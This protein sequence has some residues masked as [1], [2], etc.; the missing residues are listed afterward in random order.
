MKKLIY[1]TIASFLLINIP[2]CKKG[3][4]DQLPQDRT[5]IEQVFAH[6]NTV[7]NFLANVYSYVR[8]EAS[9]RYIGGSTSG[10]PWTGASD[11]AE[12]DWSFVFSNYIN[13]GAWGPT[14]GVVNDF[15]S[16]YYTAIR[17][18]NYFMA[19]VGEC[20]EIT[21]QANGAQLLARYIAEARGLR[22]YYYYNLIKIFGPVVITGDENIAPNAG[23]ADVQR[24]RTPYDSCVLYISS[25]MDKAAADLPDVPANPSV[26]AGRMTRSVMMAYKTEMLLTAASDLFNG[27]PDYASLKNQEG[28]QLI[29]QQKDPAKWV[30]A[31]A[32]AKAFI[33]K[34]VPGT[35]DLYR[36]NDASGNL[37]PYL[38]CRNVMF[39]DWNKEWIFAKVGADPTTR[40][41]EET[42]YHAGSDGAIRGSGG[43]GVTQQMVDAY[44][45]NNGLSIND[46]GSG[47][48]E[49]G[50]SSSDGKYTTAGTYNMWTNREPRFY[51]GITY[52][53]SKWLNTTTSSGTVTTET[54]YNGN[55]G[56]R[57][58]GNDYSPTGYIGRKNIP[59]G[60]WRSGN[61]AWVMLRLANIYLDYAEA[62]NEA[63]P[64]NADIAKYVNLI[65]QR[66]GVPDISS[67]L[68]QDQMRTAIRK[69]RRVELAFENARYFDTRRWKIAEQTDGGPFYSM[70]INAGN[71]LQ[72]PT[73]YKR[74]VFE[75]RVFQKKHYLWPIPQQELDVDKNL[76][77]NTGW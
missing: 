28:G 40:Q 31:A 64:G 34:Y 58:G 60:D 12:Y 11:E 68:S 33:D 49:N 69:E 55:S 52:N 37:D 3:Y 10:G 67:A 77:Q 30:T 16:N 53:G 70:D 38:S 61:R 50:F 43:L 46:P 65:R 29:S 76:V 9:Q 21:N 66:A 71:D 24:A 48:V 22:A 56:K 39:T 15:W 14:T 18:A 8:D 36:E 1:I 42:P 7:D 72:D 2:A 32:A 41:Y 59:P 5:T 25:E 54:F 62:L 63:S 20:K 19:H 73:F 75:N 74:T 35:F 27:N 44:F 57:V 13:V 45:M 23:L 6:K 17:S 47:Y 4:L 51:V 26:D